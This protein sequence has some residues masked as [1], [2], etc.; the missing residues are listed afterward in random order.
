MKKRMAKDKAARL[1]ADGVILPIDIHNDRHVIVIDMGTEST[2]VDAFNQDL[3]RCYHQFFSNKKLLIENK[4]KELHLCESSLK[5][6]CTFIDTH[7]A[8]IRAHYPKDADIP[9]CMVATEIIRRLP[10][11]AQAK[12]TKHLSSHAGVDLQIL[13]GHEEVELYAEAIHIFWPNAAGRIIHLGHGSL[14]IAEFDIIGKIYKSRTLPYGMNTPAK[15]MDDIFMEV[16]ASDSVNTYL[17]G[18]VMRN[19]IIHLFGEQAKGGMAEAE[20]SFLFSKELLLP[21]VKQPSTRSQKK[22]RAKNAISKSGQ[23]SVLQNK[24]SGMAGSHQ[25]IRLPKKNSEFGYPYRILN[26][27]LQMDQKVK[28]CIVVSR[29]MREALAA[30]LF[31]NKM[32]FYPNPSGVYIPKVQTPVTDAHGKFPAQ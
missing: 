2:R 10:E 4:K 11:N 24:L 21:A 27:F 17:C 18:K 23:D 8:A 1:F 9:V 3:H 32:G 13:T 29:G 20:K 19:M 28:L 14:D 31:K 7:V 6:L 5:E 15:N 16:D 25:M 22:N 30:R 12:L 26:G